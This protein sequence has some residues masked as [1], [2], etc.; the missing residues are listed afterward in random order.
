MDDVPD[1]VRVVKF[2]L[3]LIRALG[4]FVIVVDGDLPLYRVAE[5]VRVLAQFEQARVLVLSKGSAG[6]RGGDELIEVV[7]H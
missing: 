4:N 5:A 3:D 7:L 6:L 2:L 1:R